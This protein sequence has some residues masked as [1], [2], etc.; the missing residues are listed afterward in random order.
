VICKPQ[1]KSP[2]NSP[3]IVIPKPFIIVQVKPLTHLAGS[4][5]RTTVQLD[6]DDDDDEGDTL[7]RHLIKIND[8]IRTHVE[9]FGGVIYYHFRV[10]GT[11]NTN[12]IIHMMRCVLRQERLPMRFFIMWAGILTEPDKYG[13]D[14]FRFFH[15]SRNTELLDDTFIDARSFQVLREKLDDMDIVEM[16]NNERPDSK[17]KFVM[18][19]N[20]VIK[21]FRRIKQPAIR[22]QPKLTDGARRQTLQCERHQS[23]EGERHQLVQDEATDLEPGSELMPELT[24]RLRELRGN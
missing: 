18:L 14:H 1:K 8:L 9:Q 13:I 12:D 17:V 6:E 23:L 7:T 4:K 16:L 21:V 2:N 19:T 24:Q 5:L 20:I 22:N 15:S 11:V 3:K 10:N